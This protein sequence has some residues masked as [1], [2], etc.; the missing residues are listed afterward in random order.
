M[1]FIRFGSKKKLSFPVL[2][3]ELPKGI[4]LICRFVFSIHSPLSLVGSLSFIFTL[5]NILYRLSA[6]QWRITWEICVSL[7][8]V[9]LQS[10]PFGLLCQEQIC[11]LIGK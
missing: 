4:C 3:Q 9:L 10:E 8:S 11:R 5:R 1:F 2:S 7:I 6:L